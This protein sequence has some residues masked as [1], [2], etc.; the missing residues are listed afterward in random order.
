MR[1]TTVVLCCAFVACTENPKRYPDITAD[2]FL[3][4]R[5]G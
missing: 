4:Q 3:Q 1:A 2:A 5:S